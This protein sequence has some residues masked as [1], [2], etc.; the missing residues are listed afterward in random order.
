M[1]SAKKLV[2]FMIVGCCFGVVTAQTE[3]VFEKLSSFSLYDPGAGKNVQLPAGKNGETFSLFIF[4]SPE[5]PLS[6]NYLPL[7]NELKE[8]YSGDVSFYGIIP[9]RAYSPKTVSEFVSSYNILFPVLIDS[10][11]SLTN[12]M[13]ATVTPEI[14][15][16][17]NENRLIYKGA[18][19]DL[20]TG[21]GKR[22][23]KA[24]KEYLKDA[25]VQS[26][27]NKE[28]TVKRTKAVGCKINDY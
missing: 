28:V 19:D 17:N 9:G 4:L 8:R 22:R 27:D 10:L 13:A 23:V 24:T 25:I 2:L 11:R 26:L 18:V 12:Y 7:L 16:L 14:I 3:P 21:L 20:L 6:Q 5:C 15:F 1:V